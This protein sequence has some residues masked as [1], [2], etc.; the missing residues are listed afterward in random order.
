MRK[1]FTQCIILVVLPLWMNA[2]IPLADERQ[3]NLIDTPILIENDDVDA[4]G[5]LDILILS[6]NGIFFW[7]E[8]SDGA[9]NLINQHELLN[10]GNNVYEANYVDLNGDNHKDLIYRQNS[11]IKVS[12]YLPEQNKFS[13]YRLVANGS[14]RTFTTE[15]LNNDND[16]DIIIAESGG[17]ILIF[18]NKQNSGEFELNQTITSSS[19]LYINCFAI[20]DVDFDGFKD[21]V[22]GT[23]QGSILKYHNNNN[24][25]DFGTAETLRSGVENID[26][27][28]IADITLSGT[29]DVI[30]DDPD[31]GLNYIEKSDASD[32]FGDPQ[33]IYDFGHV[34]RDVKI[35]DLN[36]DGALDIIAVGSSRISYKLNYGGGV[37]D[38][39][40]LYT[41]YFDEDR[42]LVINLCDIDNDSDLDVFY[43]AMLG[44]KFGW[45]RNRGDG[46]YW[47]KDRNPIYE[48]R[49]GVIEFADMNGDEIDELVYSQSNGS[50]H[51][52]MVYWTSTCNNNTKVKHSLVTSSI[53]DVDAVD[54]DA[55]N[56]M[57]LFVVGGGH[58]INDSL[59]L[60]KNIDGKG[61]LDDGELILTQEEI[62][63]V[64]F[65][66]IDNDGDQ[67]L[68]ISTDSTLVLYENTAGDFG[69]PKIILNSD[70][71]PKVTNFI[72][73]DKDGYVD[74]VGYCL[75]ASAYPVFWIKNTDNTLEFE[76]PVTL[77]SSGYTY[78]TYAAD[79]D[80]DN[81]NDIVVLNQ[82]KLKLLRNTGMSFSYS[83]NLDPAGAPDTDLAYMADLNNDSNMDFIAYSHDDRDVSLYIN[84]GSG[85]F[86]LQKIEDYLVSGRSIMA[87]DA[88][89]DGDEDIFYE[90]GYWK[91]IMI[92]ENLT[93]FEITEEPTSIEVCPSGEGSLTFLVNDATSY[94][95]QINPGTGFEDLNNSDTINGVFT[96]KLEILE[97]TDFLS[98][99]PYRCIAYS[100]NASVN[101]TSVEVNVNEFIDLEAP[102]FTVNNISIQLNEEG[103]AS[104]TTS[105]IINTI[106]DNCFVSDT[107]VSLL[108]FDC[109]NIGENTIDVTVIDFSG[110][111][112]T[113]SAIITVNDNGNCSTST[114]ELIENENVIIYPNPTN[115]IMNLSF[116]DTKTYQV[117]IYDLLG[118][119]LLIRDD[120]AGDER[121]DISE[122]ED[123]I[124]II[125]IQ[126]GDKIVTSKIIKK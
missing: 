71:E 110:N 62:E 44:R 13:D 94:Q 11:S 111:E 16:N 91:R 80:N 96:N 99:V 6:K 93:S 98:S 1:L 106:S 2:Q 117:K 19:T 67:D 51:T 61:S 126:N 116:S 15:D 45:S 70:R 102:E 17:T 50:V 32:N 125:R 41:S 52:G 14:I 27:I 54:I 40:Q 46:Y 119:T 121:I 39:Y 5:D 69:T 84:N 24:L 18:S 112:L 4:D 79:I 56:D 8:N 33:Q 72:D 100:G 73:L 10:L 30:Y 60:F 86:T 28:L 68:F 118:K 42:V 120:I 83:H 113:K 43:A 87:H 29:N 23:D 114:G 21:I 22:I 55:D 78:N 58:Y 38:S 88:D 107:I 63:Q 36:N 49:L 26:H 123:G 20:G 37:F 108:D 25:G 75:Y 3:L 95:W 9:G 65:F 7:I 47:D 48:D 31:G 97:L 82:D 66:D 89:N 57:D 104:I 122:Y 34:I 77:Y 76:S 85:N 74:I 53:T 92:R 81:D 103:S 101:D 59:F 35:G 105:E 64:R 124:Y 90:D 109:S 115:G 12:Y